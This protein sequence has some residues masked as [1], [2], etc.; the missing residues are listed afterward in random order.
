MAGGQFNA[1][2]GVAVDQQGNIYVADTGNDRIQQFTS[3]GTLLAKWG[4]RGSGDGEFS[5]PLALTVGPDLTIYVAEE[6]NHRVQALRFK[7][8]DEK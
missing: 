5:Q 3:A 7:S 8:P 6:G 4:S 2:R 1:P